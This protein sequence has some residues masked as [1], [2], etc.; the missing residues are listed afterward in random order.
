MD[1]TFLSRALRQPMFLI[2]LALVG[3]VS[4][5]ALLAPWIAPHDP[6]ALDVSAI[7]R[8]RA[9]PIPWARTPWA[10]TCSR[11]CSSAA[12]CPCGW[13]FWPWGCR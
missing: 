1:D 5:A 6:I 12:G 11:A 2:G 4:L 3:G 7:S 10:A 13:A 8:P 9:R